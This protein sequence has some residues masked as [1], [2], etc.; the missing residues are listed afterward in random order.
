MDGGRV[1]VGDV[2]DGNGF[3]VR[4]FE[5]YLL[6]CAS[7]LNECQ[8]RVACVGSLGDGSVAG[9]LGYGSGACFNV[10]E[11]G[12]CCCNLCDCNRKKGD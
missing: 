6:V 11:D 10:V 7:M 5:C 4:L 2:V 8:L 1:L 3:V 9:G 12:C